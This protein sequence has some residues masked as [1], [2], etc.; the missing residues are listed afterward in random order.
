MKSSTKLTRTATW[1]GAVLLI[2]IVT[3]FAMPAQA[4]YVGEKVTSTAKAAVLHVCERFCGCHHH[5]HGH[6]WCSGHRHYWCPG[7]H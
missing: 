5:H 4:A 1:S 6:E 3:A 7:H 2:A